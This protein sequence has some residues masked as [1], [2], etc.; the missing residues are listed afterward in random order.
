MYSPPRLTFLSQ[1]GPLQQCRFV[2]L[3]IFFSVHPLADVRRTILKLHAATA[4]KTRH[5]SQKVLCSLFFCSPFRSPFDQLAHNLFRPHRSVA[6]CCEERL[7]AST[8][9]TTCW[10]DSHKNGVGPGS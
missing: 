5:R 3:S 2:L 8:L 4:D 9:A 6:P 1:T 7:R 10:L